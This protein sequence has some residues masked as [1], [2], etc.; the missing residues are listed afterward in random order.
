[1]KIKSIIL[2]GLLG[3]G[4]CARAS[5]EPVRRRVL[6]L[7]KSSEGD[8]AARNQTL[9]LLEQPLE[10]L[11]FVVDYADASKAL[12]RDE[13][14][15]DY[16]GVITFF[17]DSDMDNAKAYVAWVGRQVDAGR[18]FIVFGDIGA[19]QDR[20]TK[21]FLTHG[22]VNAAFEKI[23][24]RFSG[25]GTANPAL[26]K[27]VSA[28]KAMSFEEPYTQASAD[29][30]VLVRSL[31]GGAT[32]YLT[33]SRTDLS[34][35]L[36]TPVIATRHG[37]FA[38]GGP[39]LY[40]YKQGDAIKQRWHLNP[41]AFLSD[42]LGVRNEPHF[43]AASLNGRRLWMA[44]I[45][46]DG[47]LSPADPGRLC[48]Q[49]M[50]EEI[51]EK[52]PL[53]VSVSIIGDDLAHDERAA[54]IARRIFALPNIEAA[55]HSQTHPVDWTAKGVDP[56]S[57]VNDSVKA[58]AKLLPEGKRVKLITWSG[59]CN[60]PATALGAAESLGLAN[61]NGFNGDSGFVNR[62]DD[63]YPSR[64]HLSP[65]VRHVDGMLQINHRASND[66]DLTEKWSDEHRGQFRHVL[67][68][69]KRTESGPE[70][71][72]HVYFHF[73]SAHAPEA[74]EALSAVLDWS[75]RQPLARV[76]VSDYTRIVEDFRSAQ[77]SRDADGRVRVRNAGQCRTIVFPDASQRVDFSRSEHVIG[78]AARQS[79]LYVF[80]DGAGNH[81]IALGANPP[82]AAFVR[83]AAGWV[84]NWA[85]TDAALMFDLRAF[86]PT[87]ITLA[88]PADGYYQLTS[89][90]DGGAGR[91][92]FTAVERAS[93]GEISFR[94]PATGHD[95]IS[96]EPAGQSRAFANGLRFP[97]LA[98]SLAA[99]PVWF[100]VRARRRLNV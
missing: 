83:A 73:Y 29:S 57:E 54:V 84:D 22:Q 16:R 19:L 14:M 69:F 38:A 93:K 99:F 53:P 97:V 41:Y 63:L 95:Q 39:L 81:V 20:Q 12:P 40:E 26:I 90:P 55:S 76:F 52:Y 11:G 67:D 94:V 72:A 87:D 23:G 96:I 91:R 74:L 92:N 13:E 75:T 51:L 18:K 50:L 5:A 10:S 3:L 25:F 35:G 64:T 9:A 46:G 79:A 2:L 78:Y 48:G 31:E 59:L 36:S 98:L 49:A 66:Y 8:T 89:R 21:A 86:G 60:P 88:V 6:A 70:R 56:V 33:L 82:P 17:R 100:F 61:I 71:P 58:I 28:D 85:V 32:P 77:I 37:G 42:A 80:L 43:D 1:M 65:M 27:L 47:Y 15:G 68:T 62:F 45:D 34:D 24:L 30:Y 7:Y 44:H 4:L